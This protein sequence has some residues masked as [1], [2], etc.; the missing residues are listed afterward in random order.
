MRPPIPPFY[1]DNA[2]PE[3]ERR[4][5]RRLIAILLVFN[6]AAVAHGADRNWTSQEYQADYAELC[7]QIGST[8]AYFDTK[9]LQWNQV[10]ELYRPDLGQVHNRD[11]F[12][13]LLEQVIDELYDPHSQLNTNT[14]KS[15]R[16]VPSGTDLWAEWHDGQAVITQVRENS[17][18]ARAG[19][20]P[21]MSVL[22]LNGQPIAAL[23]EARLGRSYPHTT[24]AARDWALR[25]VLAGLHDIPRVLRMQ[26]G[27]AVSKKNTREF[28]LPAKDQ[29]FRGEQPISHSEI[30][31]GIGYILLNDSVGNDATVPAFDA[32]LEALSKTRGLII[33]LRDTAS[34]GNSSVA[35]GILGRFVREDL[36]YQKH[37][38][39]AEEKETGVRRSWLELVSPRGERYAGAVVVLVNR[40]TGSMGE[41]LAIGF[42]ATGAGKVVG[43]EMARLVGATYT[44][45]LPNTGIHA[46]V[47]AE[48]LQH[49][50]GQPREQFRPAAYVDVEKSGAGDDPFI[51]RALEELGA[52]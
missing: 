15:F 48:R 6:I 25:S 50:N 45:T 7:S 28:S 1:C 36:P 21:G 19:V 42:D 4:T 38:L 52:R 2:L 5:M 44:I 23:V 3:E 27:G 51:A 20:R 30:R 37:I 35:R 49:V 39:P 41:G 17:D 9:P 18:A 47:P 34:G 43:T 16:L 22:T 11:Q 29:S 31:P 24:A 14:S 46:N 13:T 40:W 12:V 10:C 33:D 8:Y 26:V 32:A